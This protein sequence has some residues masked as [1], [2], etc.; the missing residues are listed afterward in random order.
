MDKK[1]LTLLKRY[2]APSIL[3]RWTEKPFSWKGYACATNGFGALAIP[4]GQDLPPGPEDAMKMMF[5]DA[6]KLEEPVSFALADIEKVLEQWPVDEKGKKIT[7]P[8]DDA[9]LV[10]ME[11]AGKLVSFRM[12]EL[13]RLVQT[14]KGLGCQVF[15]VTHAS[16]AI[17]NGTGYGRGVLG[18]AVVVIMP[19]M[20]E[21]ED[22]VIR[23]EPYTSDADQYVDGWRVV[24]EG[25]VLAGYKSTSTGINRVVTTATNPDEFKRQVT[26]PRKKKSVAQDTQISL[27][28][29][30]QEVEK[31]A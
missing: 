21:D 19:C 1:T 4:G 8:Q 22:L 2:F 12:V 15:Q 9:H 11:L 31:E 17:G 23:V 30:I 3:D 13:K 6:D 26:R 18:S 14:G 20:C 5:R 25:G 28:D 10:G 24:Q 7:D 29:M 16:P 27:M